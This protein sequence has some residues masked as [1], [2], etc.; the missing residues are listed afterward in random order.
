MELVWSRYGVDM[1]Q[2]WSRYGADMVLVGS[3]LEVINDYHTPYNKQMCFQQST[4]LARSLEVPLRSSTL[5][6][7]AR[8]LGQ[9]KHQ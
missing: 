2:I 5:V 1:E 9:H 3:S 7:V 6:R 4:P 8:L